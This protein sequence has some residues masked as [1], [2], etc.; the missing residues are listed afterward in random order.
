HCGGGRVLTRWNAAS[1]PALSHPSRYHAV[2]AAPD[3]ICA[4]IRVPSV[5]D[6]IS[7]FT[8]FS[9]TTVVTYQSG[10]RFAASVVR[11]GPKR[12][13][14]VSAKDWTHWLRNVPNYYG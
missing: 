1:V 10:T 14:Q 9:R 12:I 11:A 4:D 8:K 7:F 5:A 3:D 6:R 13:D 2:P